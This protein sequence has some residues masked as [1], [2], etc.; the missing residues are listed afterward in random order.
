MINKTSFRKQRVAEQLQRDLANLLQFDVKD[1][2]LSGATV[3]DVEV[4][5]DLSYACVYYTVL[6]EEKQ[7]QTQQGL[8]KASGFLRNKIA[9]QLGLRHTPSLRFIYDNSTVHGQRMSQLIDQALAD[10]A[11]K[12]SETNE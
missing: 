12:L 2:R 10:D 9:K 4:S 1:P 3:V 7:Q 5:K 11:A 6:D 8:D